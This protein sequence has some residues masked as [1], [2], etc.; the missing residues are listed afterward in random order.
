MLRKYKLQIVVLVLL[1]TILG[2]CSKE[3]LPSISPADVNFFNPKDIEKYLGDIIKLDKLSKEEVSQVI[4]SLDDLDW[5]DLLTKNNKKFR[6]NLSKWIAE[7]GTNDVDELSTII[8]SMKHFSKK[9]YVRLAIFLSEKFSD[10]IIL[11]TKA[12]TK[13]KGSMNEIA[14]AFYDLALYEEGKRDL[15]E[16]FNTIVSS[17]E[18]TDKEKYAGLEF[19]EIIASCET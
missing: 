14:F 18:L 9:D 6:A 15:I 11:F 19:I 10:D 3:A 7:N 2:G 12:I 17:D 8:K 4:L 5:K 1:V 13:E 16:D